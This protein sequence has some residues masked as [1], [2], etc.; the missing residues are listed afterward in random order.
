MKPGTQ[1]FERAQ[2]KAREL[3]EDAFVKYSALARR[4]ERCQVLLEMDWD[5]GDGVKRR[6]TALVGSGPTW[7]D[8]LEMYWN[9]MQHP[10]EKREALFREAHLREGASP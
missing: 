9:W 6:S 4:S 3:S 8:A 2:R 1:E 7:P 10:P 5:L